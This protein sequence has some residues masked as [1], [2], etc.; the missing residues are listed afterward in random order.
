MQRD[1]KGRFIKNR[2]DLTGQKFGKLKAIQFSHKNKNRKTYWVF[3]CE[4][5]N[6]K[7]LR[8]DTVK[9]GKV[10]SCGCIKK[11]QDN[12]NL[13]RD[14]SEPTKYNSK[15]LSKHILYHKWLGMKRRCYDI[16]NTHYNRYG[17][18]GIQICDEWLYDF[19]KFFDWSLSNGWKD[20]LEIDR[21]DND[22]N[23]EPSNC[24]YVTRKENCNNRSTTRKITINNI[25]LSI[26]KWCNIIGVSPNKLYRHSDDYIRDCIIK[27]LQDNIEI[28]K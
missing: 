25:S 1:G 5:G 23:Y 19:K 26:S 22:G 24:R 2:E 8:T 13:N 11:E 10:K 18:R 14:G 4:C 17:A 6:I 7:T 28:T 9:S 15:G 16:H 3:E 20:N 27:Y 21:I 12:L